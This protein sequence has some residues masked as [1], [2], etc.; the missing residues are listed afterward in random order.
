MWEPD[1][2]YLAL[3]AVKD[4]SKLFVIIPLCSDC[5]I[6]VNSTLIWN[7]PSPSYKYKEISSHLKIHFHEYT[8]LPPFALTY[9]YT[10]LH[11]NA[12]FIYQ[13]AKTLKTKNTLDLVVCH[14]PGGIFS[15]F[16][17]D[18][19]M[20]AVLWNG[21]WCMSASPFVFRVRVS[22]YVAFESL[23]SW[24][25]FT[26]TCLDMYSRPLLLIA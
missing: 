17:Q 20:L 19:L 21:C 12:L 23:S 11:T 15:L 25:D 6:C 22:N 13:Y 26:F 9:L 7:H 24:V 1:L 18:H 4:L 14:F 10:S 2:H 5:C 3:K 16:C 8:Q